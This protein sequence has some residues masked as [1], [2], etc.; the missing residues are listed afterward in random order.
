MQ[1]YREVAGV[2]EGMTSVSTRFASAKILSETF[3][4]DSEEIAADPVHLMYV[5]EQA[6]K[7]EQLPKDVE[8]GISIS[9]ELSCA[10]HEFIGREIQRGLHQ[11]L[12]RIRAEP[13]RPLHHPCRRLDRAGLQGPTPAKCSTRQVLDAELLQDREAG[14]H[15]Q[16]EGLPQRDRQ[17][18]AA[19]S[20]QQQRQEPSWTAYERNSRSDREAHV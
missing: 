14:R 8:D 6:I 3:N 1:E 19:C 2:A 7:R 4:L 11:I 17:V 13:V 20:C 9:S 12:Q 16:P 10:L 15:R 18:R 5:L